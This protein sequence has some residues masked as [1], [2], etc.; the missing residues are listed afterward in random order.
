MMIQ[1]KQTDR[2]TRKGIRQTHGGSRRTLWV[3]LWLCLCSVLCQGA[4]G[5]PNAPSD[6]EN[7]L[8]L[9]KMPTTDIERELWKARVSS[10][11]DE[12]SSQSREELKS[13]INQIQ[14]IQFKNLPVTDS[15]VSLSPQPAPVDSER[16]QNTA[17]AVE[18]AAPPAEPNE[19]APVVSATATSPATDASHEYFS[20][21]VLEVFR[22][23][24]QQPEQLK[25]P[26][27][28]AEVLF[29]SHCLKEAAACYQI[30]YDRLSGD[31]EEEDHDRAWILFQ[32]GNCLQISDPQTALQKY[33]LLV[34][35][36]P[37]SLWADAAEEKSRILDWRINDDPKGLIQ[38]SKP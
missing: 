19:A 25:N 27:E 31:S 6:E 34:D 38:A 7:D 30:A 18:P 13:L 14:A 5:D 15:D 11:G 26:Y 35:T 8:L 33:R 23:L 20:E 1:Y 24:F 9:A 16:L 28:L 10:S 3:C 29:H 17:P 2:L 22:E 12:Q 32:L 37:S 4:D 36:Y 21:P